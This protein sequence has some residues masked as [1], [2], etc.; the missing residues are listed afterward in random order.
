MQTRAD[1][2]RRLGATVAKIEAA[3]ITLYPAAVK[4][5]D[6]IVRGYVDDINSAILDVLDGG[7]T[8]AEAARAHKAYI[9]RDAQPVYLDGLREGGI[10]EADLSADDKATIAAWVS[11][12]RG[13]V[14]DFWKSVADAAK[15]RPAFGP[16]NARQDL[17]DAYN[18]A[19]RG[20]FARLTL[21]ESALRE[22]AGMGKASAA[23]DMMV[24]WKLGATE[25]HCSTCNKL[26]K[27]RHRLK[28]FT[29]AGYIPQQNDSDTLDCG[30]WRCLC[31]LRDDKGKVVLPA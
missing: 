23:A 2:A 5:V 13:Y 11:E 6:S 17:L 29:E 21:W 8:S 3:V 7:M 25:K 15:L 24:T 26:N 20:L 22:L 18:A 14:S 9:K 12:Q 31:E 28:W 1:A 27:Q 30:G 10:E 4:S 19:R 16:A